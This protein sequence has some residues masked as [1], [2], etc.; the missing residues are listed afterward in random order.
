MK[1]STKIIIA[2]AVVV[3][4][5]IVLLVLRAL[6]VHPSGDSATNPAFQTYTD[7]LYGFE[8]T[9]PGDWGSVRVTRTEEGRTSWLMVLG[10][11]DVAGQPLNVVQ[12]LRDELQKGQSADDVL[13]DK[14]KMTQKLVGESARF[15]LISQGT[16]KIAGRKC[17]QALV[18]LQTSA[19]RQKIREVVVPYEN[20]VLNFRLVADEDEYGK[21]E[22]T[23]NKILDTLQ[24][25]ISG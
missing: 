8:F 9:Y 7:P 17:P 1:S 19:G 4:V 2:A 18:R 24:F 12:L 5:I 15:E 20:A 23:F 11:R 3:V 10:P 6:L 13:Q 22:R 14:L 21:Y 16:I 25:A